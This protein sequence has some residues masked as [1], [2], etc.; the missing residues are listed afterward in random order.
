MTTSEGVVKTALMGALLLLALVWA[1]AACGGVET[2]ASTAPSIS[3]QTTGHEGVETP[4]EIA[5][6]PAVGDSVTLHSMTEAAIPDGKLIELLEFDQTGKQYL[7]LVIDPVNHR[8]CREMTTMPD[9]PYPGFGLLVFDDGGHSE[10]GELTLQVGPYGGAGFSQLI[11]LYDQLS[12][13]ALKVTGYDSL[14]GGG[15]SWRRLRSTWPRQVGR[16]TCLR[17]WTR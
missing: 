9:G 10:I 11:R 16:S 3:A 4:S 2:A 17:G 13:K 1:L 6:M 8:G 15:R 12:G 7:R 5:A 14:G